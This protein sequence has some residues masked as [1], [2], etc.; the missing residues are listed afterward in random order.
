MTYNVFNITNNITII[1][2]DDGWAR[3]FLDI[4]ENKENQIDAN[5]NNGDAF[6]YKNMHTDHAKDDQAN[7]F[8]KM[9]PPQCWQSAED[10]PKHGRVPLKKVLLAPPRE[11]QS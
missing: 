1:D 6:P 5:A 8:T 2:T 3:L 9:L 10:I 7:N 4:Y 11:Q